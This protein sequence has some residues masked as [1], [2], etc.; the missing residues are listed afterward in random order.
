M[1]EF[2]EYEAWEFTRAIEKMRPDFF[3]MA[4]CRDNELSEFFPGR[5][6]SAQVQRSIAVC[7]NCPVQFECLQYALDNKIEHGVWGGSGPEERIK[8][9]EKNLTAEEAWIQTELK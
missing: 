6:Q 7:M 4:L 8:W 2:G 3:F 5:G 1:A 9:I